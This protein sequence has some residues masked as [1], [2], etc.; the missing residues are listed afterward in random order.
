[1]G[2][3][4]VNALRFESN[5]NKFILVYAHLRARKLEEGLVYAEQFLSNFDDISVNW[6]PYMENYFLIALHSAQYELADCLLHKVFTNPVYRKIPAAGKERWAL[7]GAYLKLFHATASSVTQETNPFL[8][9]LP[10]Y[11]KD[12]QGFNVAILILQFLYF[13]QKKDTE[14]LLYRIESL[15]KYILSHLKDA[16]S[17]RSKLF[18][19]LLMLTVK[20][21]L[22]PRTCRTKGKPHFEK[23]ADTPP[24]GDAFAEIEIVPYEHLWEY[25]LQVLEKRT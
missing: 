15:R 20:E 2:E 5:F 4:K 13:L 22:N 25:I 17:A 23:L 21:D 24:P 8:L 19:R 3:G 10:A 7:Y 16:F 6:F 18:L 11:S 1:L 14:A 12:K 9:S